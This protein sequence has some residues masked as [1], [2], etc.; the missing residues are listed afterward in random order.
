[1]KRLVI[2]GL[3]VVAVGVVS[4]SAVAS[5][6]SNAVSKANTSVI[7]DSTPSGGLPANLPSYGPEAYAF[8]SLGDKITFTGGPR[9]L[10]NV[11]ATL[12]SWACEH[13]TWWEKNCVTTRGATFSQPITLTIW[14][15][16]RTKQLASATQTFNVPYRPSASPECGDGRWWNGTSC[17]NGLANQVTFDFA[18]KHVTLSSTV[19]YEISYNTSHYG[20]NPLHTTG[21]YDSLNIAMAD[22]PRVGSTPDDY[23]WANGAVNADFEGTPAVQFNA[24]RLWKV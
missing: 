2:A 3:V 8:A 17:F 4:G 7:Y 18:G 21:P 9:R 5:D 15:E 19:V 14:N 16:D 13:G 1:M 11:V 10:A 20:P 22:A 12:S 23:A 24:S 6:T